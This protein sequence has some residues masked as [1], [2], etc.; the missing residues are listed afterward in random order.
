MA[1]EQGSRRGGWPRPRQLGG[2]QQLQ[3]AGRR[4][5][6]R[7]AACQLGTRRRRGS[8]APRTA[9]ARQ[10]WA[11]R[12]THRELR[13]G[14]RRATRARR[15]RQGPAAHRLRAPG[16]TDH[17]AARRDRRGLGR[18]GVVS[19]V[20]RSPE[21]V[22]AARGLVDGGRPGA[23]CASSCGRA[24]RHWRHRSAGLARRQR[25][26]PADD[27]GPR[28]RRHAAAVTHGVP[29][30]ARQPGRR[31]RAAALPADGNGQACA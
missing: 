4:A 3:G 2:L 10:P 5:E 12:A 7:A 23:G 21:P 30:P 19:Q 27:P 6:A 11:A 24:R 9:E 17:R 31:S 1:R 25:L 20:P 26:A 16:A 13:S 15:S 18:Q 29:V 28:R 14:G 22:A 8:I